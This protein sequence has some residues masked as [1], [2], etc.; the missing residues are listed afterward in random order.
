M[1]LVDENK[2]NVEISGDSTQA[3]SQVQMLFVSYL[4]SLKDT[5]EQKRILKNFYYFLFEAIDNDN[6]KSV[7]E[8]FSYVSML[9]PDKFVKEMKKFLKGGKHGK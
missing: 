8:D 1:L 7:L 2:N 3:F 6:L 4:Y 5:K 9:P